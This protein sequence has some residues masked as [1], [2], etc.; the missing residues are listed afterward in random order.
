MNRGGLKTYL[1]I[2]AML[3]AVAATSRAQQSEMAKLSLT[4]RVIFGYGDYR[5]G[6]YVNSGPSAT[7]DADLNGY[8]HDPRILQ[9]AFRPTITMGSIVPGTEMGNPLTGFSAVGIFMQGSSFPLTVAYSRDVSSLEQSGYQG[10]QNPGLLSGISLGTTN[11]IFDANWT[12]RFRHLPVVSLEYRDSSYN[13]DLPKEFVTGIDRNLKHFGAHIQYKF[14]G[15]QT[16]AWYQRTRSNIVN[17][18][19]L[20]GGIESDQNRINDYGFNVSRLLPLHSTLGVSGDKSESTFTYDGQQTNIKVENANAFLSSQPLTR[21][22]TSLQVQYT[23]N[24]QGYQLQQALAGAGVPVGG[25]PSGNG[26]S[27]LV[28]LSA[29]FSTTTVGGGIG[30]RLGHGFSFSGSAGAGRSSHQGDMIRWGAGPSYQHS[31]R[32]GSITTS[33]FYNYFDTQ[34]QIVNYLNSQAGSYMFFYQ[35]VGSNTGSV[36]L[37]QTLPAR[38]KLTANTHVGV[39]TLR[40]NGIQ[41]P[42]HDYGGLASLEHPAGDWTFTGSV[43]VEKNDAD[44]ALIY[45]ESTAKAFSLTAAHHGLN[46]SATRSYGDGLALQLG[47]SLVYINNP[48]VITP[49]IG[50]PVLS[51]T[52]GTSLVGSYRTKSGRLVVTGNFGHFNYETAGLLTNQNT[53]VN[54]RASYQLRRLRLVAGFI[55]NSQQLAANALG[56]F[57]TR[58]FYFQVE[59]VFRIF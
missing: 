42:N 22:T 36:N 40:E 30:Y 43:N 5:Q 39:G 12:L 23:S 4:S 6:D 28:Y 15:W 25:T 32:T 27:P 19:L 46:V 35:T 16:A 24:M 59:R 57:K 52:S 11:T 34:T 14:A 37:N 7:I 33:Y 48:G 10:S 50:I 58:V 51:N 53:F 45:N 41:Y 56:N 21:L 17:P 26:S 55:D 49:V 20:Q 31:W 3:I 29:P 13:S 54:L 1:V 9:F 8:W 38:F 44:H 2:I 47:D 18:N